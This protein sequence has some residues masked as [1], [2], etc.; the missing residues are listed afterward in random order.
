[1]PMEDVVASGYSAAYSDSTAIHVV[2]PVC[3][4]VQASRPQCWSCR[5]FK[6]RNHYHGFPGRKALEILFYTSLFTVPK[7]E[8]SK[9]LHSNVKVPHIIHKV[10][11]SLPPFRASALVEIKDAYLCV[12]IFPSMLPFCFVVDTKHYQFVTLQFGLTCVHQVPSP[13]AGLM[14]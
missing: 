10:C 4:S 1:M 12:L 14:F 13:L 2:Q 3:V 7:P 8:G 5:F 6:S 9:C 11:H